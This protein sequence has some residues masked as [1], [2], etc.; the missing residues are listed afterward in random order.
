MERLKAALMGLAGVGKDYLAAI[1]SDDK[2]DLVALAET[3]PEVLRRLTD[4]VSVR[5]YEDYR[6][7]VVE[8][9]RGGLDVLFVALEPYQAIEYVKL[10][11]TQGICVFHKAPFA[12]NVREARQLIR[13]F[14]EN[15]QTLAVS[16]FW[17]FEPAFSQLDEVIKSAGRVYAATASVFATAAPTRRRGAAAG[18]GSGVLLS[19]A[20]EIVDL[21]VHM[22]GLPETVYAQC[23]TDSSGGAPAEPGADDVAVVSLRFGRER[24]GCLTVLRGVAAPS[25]QVSL[26]ATRG[27]VALS[28][29][30]LTLTL[31]EGGANESHPVYT[32]NPVAAAISAFGASRLSDEEKLTSPAEQH[33]PTV[34]LIEAAYLSAKTGEA[35]SP[36]RL[37]DQERLPAS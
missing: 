8:T 30:G 13:R 1:R 2:F 19:G 12:R 6:S 16:R 17:Q 3:D 24:I 27:T 10:A 4:E 11:A 7:L 20:Y 25:W 21:L 9:A 28:E 29:K 33:L 26:V 36:A 37:L 22:L 18:G 35:E 34:A 15:D 31:R 23:A 5:V 14:L 32:D